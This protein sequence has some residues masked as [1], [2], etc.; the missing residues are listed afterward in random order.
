MDRDESSDIEYTAK[1]IEDHVPLDEC[2]IDECHICAVRD[3]PYGLIE[4]Y[5]HDGC[6]ECSKSYESEQVVNFSEGETTSI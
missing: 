2:H 5:F 3:C 1:S 4:H 6:P